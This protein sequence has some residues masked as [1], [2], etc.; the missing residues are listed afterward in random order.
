MMENERRPARNGDGCPVVAQDERRQNLSAGV[1]QLPPRMREF[2]LAL[3]PGDT[4]EVLLDDGR[5]VRTRVRDPGPW[6]M[7]GH[8]WMVLLEGFVGGYNLG[9]CRPAD[10]RGWTRR[11]QAAGERAA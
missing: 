7:G 5:V 8:T 11:L 4:V 9:R 3:R 1:R 6:E 10:W 2:V